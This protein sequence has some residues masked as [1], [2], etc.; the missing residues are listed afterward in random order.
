MRL[1]EGPGVGCAVHVEAD[2]A[3]VW[4]LVTDIRLPARLSPELRRVAWMGEADRP[5]VGARFEGWNHHPQLGEWRTV[6]HVVELDEPRV[7]AWA[8]TDAD[9]R[10]GEPTLD[11]ARCMASWRF[12]LEPEAGGTRL[13]LSVRIGPGRS[14]VSLALD[15]RPDR[16]EEIVAFRLNELRAGM[17]A[18]LRGIKS[19]AE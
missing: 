14:G 3:R 8:V 19:A 13:R 18:T 15:H 6:S 5:L 11:P 12:E 10:Y 2:V 9:G 4:E 1:A 16:E 7:F 17:E